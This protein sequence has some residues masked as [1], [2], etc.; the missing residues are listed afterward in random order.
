VTFK[1]GLD[2]TIPSY[3]KR[4]PSDIRRS[5]R[6]AVIRQL[7][8]DFEAVKS[9]VES[10]ADE[11]FKGGFQIVQD[12]TSSEPMVGVTH[13]DPVWEFVDEP[14]RPHEIPTPNGVP[15]A[16]LLRWVRAHGWSDRVAYAVQRNIYKRGSVQ[17][18]GTRGK[19]I[20]R[21]VMQRH[22]ARIKAGFDTATGR[23]LARLGDV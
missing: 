20:M 23:W 18:P 14:T 17:H 11:R 6:G 10:A 3:A 4:G 16:P 9:E 5:Y 19:Q 13:L 12:T 21:R 22:E 7:R 2:I 8:R 15:I 1:V